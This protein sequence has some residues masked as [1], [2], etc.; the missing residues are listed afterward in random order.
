MSRVIKIRKGLDIKMVG[1]AEKVTVSQ[2]NIDTVSISPLDFHGLI[3][4]AVVNVGDEVKAGTPLFFDKKN[5]E[6]QFCS[7]VSGE[8]V[9]VARGEKR[10][11]LYVKILADKE[12]SYVNFGTNNPDSMSAEEIIA[13]MCKSGVWPMLRQRP[14][15][16]V[17]NPKVKPKG[18]VV[19][20]FDSSPLAPD[21]DFIVHGCG[22]EFQT[23][24]NALAKLTNGKVHLNVHSSRTKSDVFLKA[25]N[26]QIN[27]FE[28]PHPSGNTGVQ[29]H[30]ISP[31]NKG[32]TYW[33][34]GAQEV[35]SIGRLFTEGKFNASRTYA[36][37]GSEVIRRRYVKSI[38]G[39][40]VASILAG[41]TTTDKPLRIISGNVLVG[42]K[43]EP[44]G[45]MGFYH[46]QITV[47]PEGYEREF[48]GWITP[49]FNKFSLN[50]SFFSWMTP[51]RQ[52]KLDTN[53]H[54][55]KRAFVVTGEYEK[56]FPMN[57]YP[58]YLLKSIL[59]NDIEQMEN[60]GI[61]EV[62]PED[63][64]LCEFVCTSKINTQEI[65]RSGLDSVMAEMM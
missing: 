3:P 45:Y 51:S 47:I 6:I 49:G 58:V 10:K 5:P 28:G 14:F 19:T 24:L 65:V 43:I 55:E 36:L 37:T 2:E 29:I 56:V 32:E 54:G 50:H 7:P 64:A 38:I 39:A 41:N 21:N 35:L 1:E 52:F 17:A 27:Y 11:L 53:L 30:H 16:I 31:I 8:V 18:I 60:L 33:V 57:I 42:S 25:K 22:N 26:V 48:F 13:L 44:N 20:A 46:S 63:F 9:E 61:Y 34:L 59:A 40:P 62:A 23:G 15:D 4:K 12:I